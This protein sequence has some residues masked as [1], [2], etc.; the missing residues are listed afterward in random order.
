[1]IFGGASIL[2]SNQSNQFFFD[3]ITNILINI[4]IIPK[5]GN[6]NVRSVIINMSW[7]RGSRGVL[8]P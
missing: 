2:R 4:L 5:M 1:M 6:N 7:L 3:W 8:G